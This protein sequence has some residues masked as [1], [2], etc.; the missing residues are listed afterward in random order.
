[1]LRDHPKFLSL[2]VDTSY[3]H[4]GGGANLSTID[5]IDYSNDLAQTRRSFLTLGR[6][7]L[8]ATGNSNFGYFGGGSSTPGTPV[9]STVDRIDYANDTT[10]AIARGS[11]STTFSGLA[12][13]GNSNFGYFGTGSIDRIDYSNDTATGSL[14]GVLSSTRQFLAAT[15]AAANG[16]PQ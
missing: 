3:G 6:T 4:F 8:G 10:T 14:R 7:Y 11:L 12:A 2:K 1:M 16:L 5:R 15:S 9:Y 13:T